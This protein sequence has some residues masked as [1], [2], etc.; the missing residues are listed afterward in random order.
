MVEVDLRIG[1][2]MVA[3]RTKLETGSVYVVF[4]SKV[5]TG[6]WHLMGH[7]LE[8]MSCDALVGFPCPWASTWTRQVVVN[9][10]IVIVE[11]FFIFKGF[12]MRSCEVD[13]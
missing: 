11:H 7:T 1:K 9:R 2:L 5:D 13:S 8:E 12:Q 6:S 3:N 4:V 10:V